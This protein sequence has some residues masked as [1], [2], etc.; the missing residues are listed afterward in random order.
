[1]SS[2]TTASE[3]DWHKPVGISLA[4]LSGV[5]I[6]S[7][8]ILK[9]KG[10]LDAKKK[11]GEIGSGHAYM[12][13][14]LWWVGL[15]LMALGEMCNFGAY[16][17]VPAILVTPLGALSVVI[18]AILSSYFLEEHL[19]FSGKIGCAQCVIGATIIVLNAPETSSAQTMPEFFA[20]VVAP[21]FLVYCGILMFV[22][23]YL[24]YQV[25]P[26]YGSKYPIVYISI[27]SMVGS[28]LV[29]SIQGFGT[30]IV[31]SSAHWNDDNQ[32]RYW[33]MYLL[34]GFV[35]FSVVSQIHFL[36]KALNQFS[37]AIVTPVYYVF[38][39]TMTLLTSA[40]LFQGFPVGSVT[41]GLM[42]I[43]GFL[44]IVGGVALLFEY[45]AQMNAIRELEKQEQKALSA[46]GVVGLG[47]EKVDGEESEGSD[48]DD[49]MFPQEGS[50]SESEG[51]DLL[52]FSDD[53]GMAS[54]VNLDPSAR[55]RKSNLGAS[56]IFS[57][58]GSRKVSLDTEA[59]ADT[60]S[61]SVHTKVSLKQI[62]ETKHQMIRE[63]MMENG[64]DITPEDQPTTLRGFK[65]A[66]SFTQPT[67]SFKPQT[68]KH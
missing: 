26:R 14:P 4:L 58:F 52:G 6:G 41:S 57:L 33:T 22:I 5:F 15:A 3:P 36:N 42:M 54:I 51:D 28:F 29:V 13:S 20:Y 30:S 43:T 12:S 56:S 23:L 32:F 37:T 60:G 8:F 9:K 10:L 50:E 65:P 44:V 68:I 63:R 17:F 66:T 62:A 24:I 47:D 61:S 38:F 48:S 31:Y 39:T 45:N 2:S 55:I 40:V 34:L 11:H 46:S 1:M 18:S 49:E 27:C 53:D 25:S 7:S 35:V 67:I 16:A 64:E 19:N 21:G 59:L